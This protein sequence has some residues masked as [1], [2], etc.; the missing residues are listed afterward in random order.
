MILLAGRQNPKKSNTNAS[1]GLRFAM[2]ISASSETKDDVVNGTAFGGLFF[3]LNPCAL[4]ARMFF[5]LYE[6]ALLL[7]FK[8]TLSGP[9]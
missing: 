9:E 4:S 6:G 7:T 5:S 2:L 1:R 8:N 3:F